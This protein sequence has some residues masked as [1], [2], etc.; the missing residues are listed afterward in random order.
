MDA[1]S[2]ILILGSLP[3][4]ASLSAGQYYAHPRNQ[5]WRLLGDILAQPLA[6]MAYAAR[7][8]CL[9]AHGIGLWDVVASAERRGSL[10]A[11]LRQVSHNDLLTLLAARPQL[12][13]LAFNGA[14]AWRAR[15][16]L[17]GAEIAM[18]PLPSSSPAY[19]LDYASKLAVWRN[20]T[21]YLSSARR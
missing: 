13:L 16:P 1:H 4:Q 19:T 17:L 14:T 9:L 2:R 12:R 7:L 10:D 11:A 18:L 3:G 21:Q 6:E 20:I 5:F 8:E 15:K